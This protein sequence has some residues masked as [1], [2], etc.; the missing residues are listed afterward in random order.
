MGE[1][2]TDDGIPVSEL[3]STSRPDWWGELLTLFDSRVLNRIS[4]RMTFTIAWSIA[5]ATTITLGHKVEDLEAFTTFDLPGWPHELVGGF[6]SILLVFRTDQ[7]YGRFWEAR[8]QWSQ[9]S[10]ACRQMG[11]LV[12]SNTEGDLLHE[13]MAHTAAFPV[14]LK[15][16]LRGTKNPREIAAIFNTYL[17]ANSSVIEMI[18]ESRTMPTTVLLSMSNIAARLRTAPRHEQKE[19]LWQKIENLI[20]EMADV[21]SE[22]EKLKCSPLPLSYSRHTSRFFSIF[23]LTLPFAL[24]KETSPFL[25]PPICAFVSWVLFVTE[26]I[27][28]VIEEPFGG[29]SGIKDDDAVEPVS[30]VGQ[31]MTDE[32]VFKMFTD[33]DSDKSG[34]IEMEDLRTALQNSVGVQLSAE[35]ANSIMS[36][37]DLNGDGYIDYEEFQQAWSFMTGATRVELKQLETLPLGMYCDY[38]SREL[39]YHMHISD[40]HW[41]ATPSKTPMEKLEDQQKQ[42]FERMDKDRSGY[43][44]RREMSRALSKRYNAQEREQIF[45]DMDLNRDGVIDFKEFQQAW[46]VSDVMAW[47]HEQGYGEYANNF[48][49]N[50]VDGNVLLDLTN[51]DLE[52][53]GVMSVGKRK[54][55]L[56]QVHQ[57]AK[58]TNALPAAKTGQKRG[59][60]KRLVRRVF[61]MSS[62]KDEDAKSKGEDPSKTSAS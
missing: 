6:L 38:I 26:E 24:I 55:I 46:T 12:M 53:I 61:G 36:R 13:L 10:S 23:T 22:C 54:A 25:I 48:R 40:M 20:Q 1:L 17:P 30:R 2:T 33:M 15:Q 43:L 52:D 57:F 37:I 31:F 47:L 3:S 42:V 35:E 41:K 11:R 59:S 28:H 32:D 50:D 18:T 27:G 39:L 45:D 9:L 8:K 49:I 21:V 19:Q 60:V 34:K 14:T 62:S 16:H 51:E 44:D 5:I 4:L 7:A 56:E 29:V 58:G